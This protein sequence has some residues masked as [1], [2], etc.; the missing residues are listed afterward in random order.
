[1]DALL[2]LPDFLWR[3]PGQVRSRLRRERRARSGGGGVWGSV[4]KGVW[5]S[6]VSSPSGVWGEAPAANAFDTF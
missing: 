2:G 3:N 1:M 4:D 6:V 5:G